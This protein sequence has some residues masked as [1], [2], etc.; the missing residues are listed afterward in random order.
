MR[1]VA[2]D[3]RTNDIARRIVAS[4]GQADLGIGAYVDADAVSTPVL[5][6][7]EGVTVV[8]HDAQVSLYRQ[9][10]DAFDQALKSNVN[11]YAIDPGGPGGTA[12]FLQSRGFSSIDPRQPTMYDSCALMCTDKPWELGVV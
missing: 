10:Q 1:E 8:E 6:G 4:L 5:I 3:V 12:D 11:I 2:P 7:G 9:L